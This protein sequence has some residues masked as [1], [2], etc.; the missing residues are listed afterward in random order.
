MPKFDE[1][2]ITALAVRGRGD[3]EPWHLVAAPKGAWLELTASQVVRDV[4]QGT[5]L[6][7]LQ[8]ERNSHGLHVWDSFGDRRLR[9][10]PECATCRAIAGPGEG[11]AA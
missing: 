10:E 1:A 9:A 4:W 6:C 7:G 11:E 5:A 3:D 2:V 8:G